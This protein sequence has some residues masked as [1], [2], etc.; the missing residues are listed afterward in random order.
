M[1]LSAEPPAAPATGISCAAAFSLT[2][3][4]KRAAMRVRKLTM[5]GAPSLVIP[6]LCDVGGGV[7][8]DLGEG[9]AGSVICAFEGFVGLALRSE[10]KDFE[11]GKSGFGPAKIFSLAGGDAGDGMEH[12]GC[13]HGQLE[14]RGRPNRRS[15]RW[16]P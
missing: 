7:A 4:P 6:L 5:A 16:R 10:G 15:R 2:S 9:G 11:A 14:G 1:T 8:G 3:R 13:G 12:D